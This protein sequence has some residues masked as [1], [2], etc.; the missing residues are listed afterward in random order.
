MR[1][2][3]TRLLAF[4]LA[5]TLSLS[6]L[7]L[8]P[9]SAAE[10]K[11]YFVFGALQSAQGREYPAQNEP[12]TL[13]LD[14]QAAFS[15]VG[16]S[17][18][19]GETNALYLSLINQSNATKLRV[20]YTYEIYGVPADE[21][22]EYPLAAQSTQKQAFVLET[23]HIGVKN[24]VKELTIT[25][26]GEG[27]VSGNI[28][29][30]AMFNISSYVPDA[31]EE[32]TFSRCHYN[33]QTGEIQIQGSLSYAATVRYEGETLALFAL[34]EGEDL[35]LSSKMPIARADI[36][37]NFS[38]TV[39]GG[40]S[41]ARFS[42]Y[43]VAAVT[44]K[45]ER[46]PLCT[47]TY[48]AFPAADIPREQG[49]KGIQ[50]V[51]LGAMMDVTPDVGVVDVYLNRLL[52]TQSDG[53]LY[54]GEYDYYYFDQA[55]LSE[56]D[57][58]IQNLVGIG[59]H[60]YLRLLIDGASTGL[61]FVDTAPDGVQYRLPVIRSKQA[62]RDLF[63]LT[64][65]LSARY[66]DKNKISGLILGRAADL[67]G[68]YSYCA[69]SNLSEY[70]TLYAATV[71]LVVG[72]ARR[73]I[74]SLQALLPI[75]D[76]V[77]DESITAL[78]A[79]QNYYGALFLPS[80]LKALEAQTLSAQSFA[81]LLESNTLTDRVGG[82]NTVAYGT[83]RLPLLLND[84]QRAA[85]KSTYLQADIFFSWQV[86]TGVTQAELRADYLLKYA[87]LYQNASIGAFLVDLGKD[88]SSDCV[89]ALVHM[90]KYINTDRYDDFCAPA[91]ETIG[92]HSITDVYPSLQSAS[93]R[94]RRVVG[95]SLTTNGYATG[96]SAVGSYPFWDFS[97][98]TD[99]LGWYAGNGCTS[100]SVISKEDE[101]HTLRGTCSSKGDY[102]DISYHFASAV[103][104]SFAPLWKAE[105]AVSGEPGTRYELQLRLIG[106]QS[107]AYA[108]AIVTAGEVQ[109][110]FF[111]LSQST[112]ALT[113]LRSVRVMARPLDTENAD[114]EISV[115][116]IMIES[117]THSSTTL[118]EYVS[119]I[120][121][122]VT[123]NNA[124][125]EEEKDYTAEI[126]ITGGVLL[127]SA[128]I[129]AIL[130]VTY[131]VKRKRQ[132]R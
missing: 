48:P 5:L 39:E 51:G 61:S 19:E 97:A 35:H 62:Q 25:F 26:L 130:I 74:P 47:P 21:S 112:F 102:A 105:L 11:E 46:I 91:L 7:S 20:S 54:A 115:S 90:I 40:S 31:N 121:E 56:L 44:A 120:R 88:V 50:G 123:E 96:V 2:T 65:F 101:S 24:N 87:A 49:F 81:V 33:D 95:L 83:D 132:T 17:L 69:A 78:Q 127:I 45:G 99:H 82:E 34:A 72:A 41:D 6:L 108:S 38:F 27:T 52:S 106:D 129:A 98:A 12:I 28:T 29:L 43:V 15:T 16:L 73:N 36:S 118:A 13:P 67:V 23:P 107:V 63:A 86:P 100:L 93:F 109:N 76:R 128:S 60:V 55:Y 79:T 37:F 75:S 14:G 71:N 10:E 4:L 94:Q 125:K 114:F 68:E 92:L 111:D 66:A 57:T 77:F 9:A 32:A 70:A 53:I 58:Q 117:G 89:K 3:P 124:V 85:A 84:I 30:N 59:S 103:D 42:R 116:K 113:H 119:E 80:L 122:S 64:D 126:L 18:L 1:K 131:R 8:L 110:L 22:A 104:L